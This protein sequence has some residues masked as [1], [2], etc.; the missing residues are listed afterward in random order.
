M[1]NHDDQIDAIVEALFTIKLARRDPPT[2]MGLTKAAIKAMHSRGKLAAEV[3]KVLS[4]QLGRENTSNS[5]RR[6]EAQR[7]VEEQV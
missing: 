2:Q 7:P 3:A 6:D 1:E 5:G 4:R